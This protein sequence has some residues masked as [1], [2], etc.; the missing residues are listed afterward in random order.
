MCCLGANLKGPTSNGHPVVENL[1]AGRMGEELCAP[2][3]R[4]IFWPAAAMLV[5]TI[6]GLLIRGGFFFGRRRPIGCVRQSYSVRGGT[7]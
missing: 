1:E 4:G 2:Q 6:S 3:N 7:L 5:F